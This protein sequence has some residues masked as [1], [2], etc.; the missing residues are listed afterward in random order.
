MSSALSPIRYGRKLIRFSSC[1]FFS[2]V[3]CL[4]HSNLVCFHLIHS[5]PVWKVICCGAGGCSHSL[6]LGSPASDAEF[7]LRLFLGL[8]LQFHP[9]HYIMFAPLT[10]RNQGNRPANQLPAGH[11]YLSGCGCLLIGISCFSTQQATQQGRSL[12]VQLRAPCSCLL[13]PCFLVPAT[14]PDCQLLTPCQGSSLD[15]YFW[16][17][18][19]SV[20]DPLA[21]DSL[22]KP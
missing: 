19:S 9:C 7:T 1:L 3:A 10:V 2:L 20:P 22:V 13:V 4:N 6:H 15:P 21:C 5:S 17:L 18:T 16:L 11:D 12:S 14:G 8:S